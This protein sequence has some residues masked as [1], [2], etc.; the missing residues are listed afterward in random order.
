MKEKKISNESLVDELERQI[1]D[2]I[3]LKK[4]LTIGSLVGFY[5]INCLNEPVTGKCTNGSNYQ[6]TQ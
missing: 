4:S 1:R 5:P 6:T 3:K 2:Q